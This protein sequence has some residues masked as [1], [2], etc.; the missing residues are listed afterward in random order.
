MTINVAPEVLSW[1]R[2]RAGIDPAALEQKFPALPAWERGLAAP[3]F[4]QLQSFAKATRAPLG[5]LLLPEPPN[6]PVPIPDYRTFGDSGVTRPSVDLLDQIYLVEQRQEWYRDHQRNL[7]AEPLDFVGSVDVHD[8]VVE[9]AATIAA[10]IGFTLEDRAR[11]RSWSEALRDLID[12]IEVTG[13]LVMISGVVGANTRRPLDPREFRGFALTDPIAPVIFVNGKDTKAAQIFTLLHELVH[14]WMG[15]SA[16]SD[17][18]MTTRSGHEDERFCNKVAA[19]TLVPLESLRA[20]WADGADRRQ[21]LDR[22][23]ARYRVSTLV[24]LSRVFDLGHLPWETY[25]QW[26]AEELAYVL[27]RKQQTASDGGNY[28]NSAPFQMSRRFARAVIADTLE[29]RTLHRDAFRM[30]GFRSAA[31]LTQLGQRLG[32]A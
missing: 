22:I 14:I 11:Y 1:A 8:D 16:L 15:E 31:T 17:A 25:R 18:S 12:L 9:V 4:A 2:E 3:T 32:V 5:Y 7:G 28:Y 29:G 21:E 19:E 27:A 26:Y 30:L 6:E 13:V 10:R 20:E 23:A 24:A